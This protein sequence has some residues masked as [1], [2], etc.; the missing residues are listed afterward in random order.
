VVASRSGKETAQD[1]EGHDDRG[2]EQNNLQIRAVHG[3]AVYRRPLDEFL[4]NSTHEL[5][6]G[7][8]VISCVVDFV[9]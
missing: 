3:P 8:M 4:T 7:V 2:F 1:D 6:T 9:V 5:N